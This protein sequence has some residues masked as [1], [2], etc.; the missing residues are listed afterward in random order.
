MFLFSVFSLSSIFK[1]LERKSFC[2]EMLIIFKVY[3]YK[4]S[5]LF[6]CDSIEVYSFILEYIIYDL[7]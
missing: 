6:V 5:F 4:I 7:S 2:H 1:N 3:V